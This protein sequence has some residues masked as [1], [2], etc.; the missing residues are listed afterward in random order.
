MHRL[1]AEERASPTQTSRLRKRRC[2]GN[3][4]KPV[5]FSHVKQEAGPISPGDPG[6]PGNPPKDRSGPQRPIKTGRGC[7]AKSNPCKTC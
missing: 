7:R 2:E 1:A 3:R 6:M 4:E 5:Q